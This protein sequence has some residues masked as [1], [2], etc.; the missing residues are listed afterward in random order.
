[1]DWYPEKRWGI[2]DVV[3]RKRLAFILTA[4]LLGWFSPRTATASVGGLT[5]L[6]GLAGCV[7]ETGTGGTCTDGRGLDSAISV[8]LSPDGNFVYTA[9]AD[10]ST[11]AIFSRNSGTGALTQLSGTAGC[12]AETGDGV[13]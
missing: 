13:T 4:A 1:M 3:R 7:S 10:S 12:V 2:V 9:A 5:Q 6:S 11:V 8:A